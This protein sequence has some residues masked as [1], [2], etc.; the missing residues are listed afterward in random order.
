MRCPLVRDA[1]RSARV[2]GRADG[3]GRSLCLLTT[4]G[5]IGET[6]AGDRRHLSGE[7]LLQRY[8]AASPAGVP[9]RVRNVLDLPSTFISPVEMLQISRE[10]ERARSDKRVAGVVVTHGSA[11]LEE[12]AY[13]VDLFVASGKPVVF[14]GS[15]LTPDMVGYDG[16]RNLVDALTVALAG[17]AIGQG[18]LVVLN[19]EIFPARDVAKVHANALNAFRSEFGP[20]GRVQWGKVVF[21]RRTAPSPDPLDPTRVRPP[22]ARVELLRC[23]AGMDG[24]VVRAIVGLGIQG[25]VIESM[26]GGGVTASVEVA[27]AEASSAGVVVV[28]STRCPEGRVWERAADDGTIDGYGRH[29]RETA[30]V[31]FTGSNGLKAR[32]KLIALLSSSLDDDEA[33]ARM[34]DVPIAV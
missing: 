6:A 3:H 18:V 4:G 29:L 20:L 28:A 23:Y 2:G 24:D 15:L 14:T 12:T 30:N 22:L 13:F 9:V 19:G 34:T 5:T 8:G 11:G 27:L 32:L 21:A 33:R 7:S 31:I 1:A 25:L 10:I 26:G 17:E 16:G